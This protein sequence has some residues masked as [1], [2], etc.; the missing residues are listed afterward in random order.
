MYFNGLTYVHTQV[1]L[2]NVIFLQFNFPVKILHACEPSY[3]FAQIKRK[4]EGIREW[5]KCNSIKITNAFVIHRTDFYQLFW[6]KK[7][8]LQWNY[9]SFCLYSFGI[10]NMHTQKHVK[11][12]WAFLIDFVLFQQS[13]TTISDVDGFVIHSTYSKN[14]TECCDGYRWDLIQKECIRKLYRVNKT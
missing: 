2:F 13:H 11:G 3:N 1:N 6:E 8:F 10:E 12:E 9:A 7:W 4:T 5:K 14:G